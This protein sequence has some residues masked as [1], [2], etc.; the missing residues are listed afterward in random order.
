MWSFDSILFAKEFEL[1]VAFYEEIV[2]FPRF[3][4]PYAYI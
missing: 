2:N 3:H 1:C 4:A